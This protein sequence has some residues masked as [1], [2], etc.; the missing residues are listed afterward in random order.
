MNFIFIFPTN[1]GSGC[2]FF[3]FTEKESVALWGRDGKRESS[4]G[5]LERETVGLCTATL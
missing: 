2:Y 5:G 3:H 4:D 1:L